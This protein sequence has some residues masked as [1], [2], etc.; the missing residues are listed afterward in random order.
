MKRSAI[1]HY[2]FLIVGRNRWNWHIG[3]GNEAYTALGS[4]VCPDPLQHDQKSVL[5]G[6]QVKNMNGEPEK[7]GDWS[8]KAEGSKLDD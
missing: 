8:V 3:A 7:P 2:L 1:K 5:E 6:N 4:Q